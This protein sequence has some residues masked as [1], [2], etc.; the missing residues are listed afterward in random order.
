MRMTKKEICRSALASLA[1]KNQLI[2]THNVGT[3]FNARIQEGSFSVK[4]TR[5][6]SAD[7]SSQDNK[8]KWV[9]FSRKRANI[10]WFSSQD[11]K[12]VVKIDIDSRLENVLKAADFLAKISS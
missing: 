6:N 12:Y 2:S 9:D 3:V 7:F 8:L 5:L 10:R 4:S 1:L 11:S